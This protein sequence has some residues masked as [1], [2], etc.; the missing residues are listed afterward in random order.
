MATTKAI[1]IPDAG[2]GRIVHH[3]GDNVTVSTLMEQATAAEFYRAVGYLSTWNMS[4][5]EVKLFYNVRELEI[6]ASYYTAT[7][8][9]GYCIGAVFNSASGKF[10]FHS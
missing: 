7:G 1:T 9:L 3:L 6:T 2:E 8:E 5:P 10:G 4:F